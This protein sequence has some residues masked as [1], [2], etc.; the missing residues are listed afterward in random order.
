MNEFKDTDKYINISNKEIDKINGTLDNDIDKVIAFGKSACGKQADIEL[1]LIKVKSIYTPHSF[2]SIDALLS[3][4]ENTSAKR[5][6]QAIAIKNLYCP[7]MTWS[8]NFEYKNVNKP[9]YKHKNH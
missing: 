6:E 7:A 1:V 9:L 2:E 4:V 3:S 8:N 5:C